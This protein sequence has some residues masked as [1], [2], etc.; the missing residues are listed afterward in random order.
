MTVTSTDLAELARV[1]VESG[2]GGPEKIGTAKAEA[3]GLGLFVR[4]LAGPDQEPVSADC[5][6]QGRM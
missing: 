3:H 1:L 2:V 4:S 5:T 6:V